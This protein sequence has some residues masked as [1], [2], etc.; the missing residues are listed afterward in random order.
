VCPPVGR[1]SSLTMFGFGHDRAET[2]GPVMWPCFSQLPTTRYQSSE[3]WSM[4]PMSN[5]LVFGYAIDVAS[6]LVF[7]QVAF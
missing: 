6:C 4:I 1:T 3:G 5:A 7:L 2:P